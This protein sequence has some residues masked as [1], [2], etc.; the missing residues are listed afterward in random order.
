[1]SFL[2]KTYNNHIVINFS[3]GGLPHTLVLEKEDAKNMFIEVEKAVRELEDGL[4]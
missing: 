2:V 4:E 1:M 3:F